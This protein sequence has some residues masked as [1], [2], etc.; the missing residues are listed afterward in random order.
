MFYKR[1]STSNQISW[2]NYWVSRLF[3]EGVELV[4]SRYIHKTVCIHRYSWLIN[5]FNVAEYTIKI[6]GMIR[7]S[8]E[9]VK[10]YDV[11]YCCPMQSQNLVAT[12]SC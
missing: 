3:Q 9:L 1:Y 4:K 5:Y 8:I 12:R 2:S 11:Q 6:N 7:S 10:S